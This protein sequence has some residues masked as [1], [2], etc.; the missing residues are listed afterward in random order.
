MNRI[1]YYILLSLALFL[2]SCA[3]READLD[4]FN[5]E[6]YTPE[7]AQGFSILGA[8]GAQ[9]TVLRIINPWQGADNITFDVFLARNGEKAPKGF[10]GQVI[11][12]D[13]ERIVCMS[14]TYVAML[15][16]ISEVERVVG[17]SGVNFV[18]NQYVVQNR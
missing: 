9:S 11:N 10:N 6:I 1:L 18:T 17:V 2:S 4:N 14:S 13:A 3:G 16:S 7:Y 12:G 8:E 15:E 5:V